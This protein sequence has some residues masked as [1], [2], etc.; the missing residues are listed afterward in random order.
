MIKCFKRL[1]QKHNLSIITS[2]HQP[3]L[4]VLMKFDKLYVLAKGGVTIFSGRPHKL[5]SHLNECHIHCTQSQIPIEV[6]LKIAAK[7]YSDEKVIQLSDK[8]NNNLKE[9]DKRIDKELKHF[10]NGIPIRMKKFSF[11][12]LNALLMRSIAYT[13]KH[14]WKLVFGLIVVSLSYVIFVRLLFDFD[15]EGPDSCIDLISNTTTLGCLRTI[16]DLTKNKFIEYNTTFL[17]VC[18]LVPAILQLFVTS[19]SFSSEIRIFNNEYRNCKFQFDLGYSPIDQ[20]T[21]LQTGIALNHI[22]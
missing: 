20:A 3:N 1:S 9:Y 8:T 18:T 13:L 2:I 11:E 17:S 15:M 19:F 6:L 14:N 21:L 10:P 16:A 12:E 22:L 5:R 4:E 7:G